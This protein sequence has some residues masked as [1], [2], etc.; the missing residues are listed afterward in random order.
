MEQTFNFKPC[1][2][3]YK[4]GPYGD[5]QW[6]VSLEG[7]TLPSLSAPTPAQLPPPRP[8]QHSHLLIL[9]SSTCGFPFLSASISFFYNINK[10][11]FPFQTKSTA[12]VNL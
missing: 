1:H 2:L 12:A 10:V 9:P 5:G 3:S 4:Y 11:F 6:E 8:P 7:K